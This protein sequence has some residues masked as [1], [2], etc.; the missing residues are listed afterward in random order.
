MNAEE[1]EGLKEELNK[2]NSK[3]QQIL[4]KKEAIEAQIKEIY[5]KYNVSSREELLDLYETAKKESEVL[6]K[7]VQEYI[8]ESQ[9]QIDKVNEVI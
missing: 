1:Y 3:K 5:K 6:L 7:E 9:A 8:K 2:V 4:G